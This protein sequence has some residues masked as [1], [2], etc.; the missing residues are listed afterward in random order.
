MT[1]STIFCIA[2]LVV[3]FALVAHAIFLMDTC[4]LQQEALDW[5]EDN[6]HVSKTA[7]AHV[8]KILA[9]EFD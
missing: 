9:G 1:A 2:L 7:S 3:C 6:G 8:T 4:R 5:L